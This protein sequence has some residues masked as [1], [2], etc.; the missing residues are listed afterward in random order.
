M[1]G[2]LIPEAQKTG[3]PTGAQQAASVSEVG[4]RMLERARLYPLD[5]DSQWFD[6]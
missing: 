4:Q 1:A 6:L 3:I 2:G 5:R